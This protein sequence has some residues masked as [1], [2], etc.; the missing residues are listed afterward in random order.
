MALRRLGGKIFTFFAIFILCGIGA[1]VGQD[2][3]RFD[4]LIHDFGKINEVDGAVTYVFEFEN[5]GMV[6]YVIDHVAVSCGCTT[7][8]YDKAPVMP[9]KKGKISITYDPAGR[10]GAFSKDVII[11]A[12]NRKERTTLV[13]TGDVAGR[14]RTVEENYPISLAAGLRSDRNSFLFGY[15]SRGNSGSRSIELYNSGKD[16]A[17]ISFETKGN[18][19]ESVYS[20]KVVPEVI[21]P[22][23][24]GEMIFTYDLTRADIWGLVSTTVLITVNGK[25]SAMDFTAYSTITEDFTKLTQKQK[26]NAPSGEFSSQFHHFNELPEGVTVEHE[27]VLVNKGNDPLI[28]RSV[29]PNSSKITA[30]VDRTELKKGEGAIFKVTL[31]TAGMDGRVSESVTIILND[32]SR[33]MRELRLAATV[34]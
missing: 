1:A 28:I 6:P 21:G 32:P 31:N 12:N 34:K 2:V 14:P 3:V 11:T 20:V 7:P 8:E 30:T 19:P 10:P 17:K 16:P 18:V 9:G 22:G 23:E 29:L 33:P 15:M 5:I 27:F 4:K 24:K 25:R 26:E 13:I